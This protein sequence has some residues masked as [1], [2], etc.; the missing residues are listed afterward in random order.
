MSN[1]NSRERELVALGASLASNC[2]P[3]IE[4]HIK[5]ARE[6]GLSDAEIEA[7]IRLADK[8]RRVPAEKVLEVA[9][10]LLS[11][12]LPTETKVA[13]GCGCTAAS[14]AKQCC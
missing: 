10:Q 14:A 13:P 3:C 1:L 5:A 11:A 4:H 7:A 12:A 6:A 9:T 2:V 8:V